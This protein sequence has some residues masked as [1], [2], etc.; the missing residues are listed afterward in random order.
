MPFAITLNAITLLPFTINKSPFLSVENLCFVSKELLAKNILS[1][2]YN[3]ADDE[4]LSTNDVVAI[5]ATSLNKNP[6]LWA[7]KVGLIK[8]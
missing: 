1:G 7:L 3:V 4:P 8:M 6:K 2:V 5:W